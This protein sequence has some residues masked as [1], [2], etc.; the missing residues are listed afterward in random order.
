MT[1]E[2]T[3]TPDTK[4]KTTIEHYG[5]SL[6][7]VACAVFLALAWAANFFESKETKTAEKFISIDKKFVAVDKDIA[8]LEAQR[9]QQAMIDQN[10]MTSINDLKKS[11][12][13]AEKKSEE[14]NKE[15]N[16]LLNK[17]LMNSRGIK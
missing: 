17:I 3:I 4:I 2:T 12:S 1:Y 6:F 8:A 10:L 13:D 11:L 14:R 15:T 7:W 5:K 16:A 9:A